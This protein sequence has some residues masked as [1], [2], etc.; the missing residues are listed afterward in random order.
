LGV[1]HKQARTILRA[2]GSSEW[3][4]VGKYA[5]Q[6]DYY[7]LENCVRYWELQPLREKLPP[8]WEDRV[9][10]G[11]DSPDVNVSLDARKANTE[12]LAEELGCDANDIVRL[13][14]N[15]YSE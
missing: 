6:V 15:D 9:G 13:Y 4:H 5:N 10:E 3:H 2:V 7:D 8:N 1:T 11:M 14:Y 12:R